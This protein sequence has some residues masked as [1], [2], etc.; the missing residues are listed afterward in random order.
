LKSY[1]IVRWSN[2]A[3]RLDHSG[4]EEGTMRRERRRGSLFWGALIISTLAVG[5]G[6]SPKRSFSSAAE[7]EED[8]AFVVEGLDD[9]APAGPDAGMP[10]P[11]R[12]DDGGVE[13]PGE[14]AEADSASPPANDAGG[15]L[16]Q[17]GELCSACQ[18]HD[19]CLGQAYCLLNSQ[20]GERFCGRDCT[21]AACPAGYFCQQ[22]VAGGELFN[23]CVPDT[24]SCL[25][26]NEAL[27]ADA[28]GN[29]YE[30]EVLERV[31]Q[32]REARGLAPLAC[33]LPAAAVAR[34]YS[35]LMCD[36][37]TFS[38][39]GPDG[40][41]PGSRLRSGGVSFS[42]AGENVAAGQPTP[43]SVMQGWM[44]SSAHRG[45]ILSA[46]WTHLGVGYA[47]CG[48]YSTRWTQDFL[49]K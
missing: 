37:G 39:Y 16:P 25:D 23:Q 31:N 29:T 9:A 24:Q 7:V 47:R 43:A 40:S 8:P 36:E 21:T 2:L 38:H 30:T 1:D 5:C 15:E 48:P 11:W 6:E 42:G 49:R 27:A 46:A 26:Q 28:C 13:A 10:H 18:T 4:G 17:A 35:Q 34:A 3:R 32:E 12:D 19:E 41:T 14:D 22:L 44:R 45:N 20:T 33:D